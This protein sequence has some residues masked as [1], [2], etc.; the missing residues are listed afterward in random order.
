MS[1]QIGYVYPP[2]Y[3]TP[4]I[5]C[6]DGELIDGRCYRLIDNKITWQTAQWECELLGSNLAEISNE[7]QNDKIITYFSFYTRYWIGLRLNITANQ[8]EWR[9]G[10]VLN[11]SFVTWKSGNDPSSNTD[12]STNCG[13]INADEWVLKSCDVTYRYLCQSGKLHILKL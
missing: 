7:I 10:R 8:Y 4:Q 6:D 5:G 9:S 11:D 2:L 12:N 3:P 13:H 1:T